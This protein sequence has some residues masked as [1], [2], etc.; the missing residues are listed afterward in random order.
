[1]KAV[2]YRP[3]T[4]APFRQNEE[5]KEVAPKSPELSKYIRCFWGSGRPYLKKETAAGLVT[6]DTCAD[7]I[8]RID[9][10]ANTIS[11]GFC[12][13]NDASFTEND[14]SAAGHLVS[15][16]A[17]RF[18][19]W[20]ACGFSEDSMKD[21]KN[22]YLDVQ[23]RFRWFDRIL[24]P[25]LFEKNSLE[26]R[27]EIAEALLLQR[28][29]KMR[30]SPIICDAVAR[31]LLQK[32]A[33]SAAELAKEC[34]ISDR[35]LE[36]LFHEYIGITPKKICNLIRY[37]F[38]WNDVLRNPAFSAADAAWQYGYTDQSHLLREFKRYHTMDMQA[39]RRYAHY[40]GN[41]QYQPAFSDYNDCKEKQTVKI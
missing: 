13:I 24:R 5:Y 19:A 32:G 8:Y 28:L 34:F 15:V 30:R 14:D 16:F 38:V 9:Y 25:Q 40:V 17:I 22:Q 23:S 4:A 3:L 31:M 2:S 41:I 21:T 20:S 37:Q 35:Q 1:M 39:A 29:S 10:T 6:P 26:E 36:R 18:Y 7:I 27:I 12:G 11:G 33:L